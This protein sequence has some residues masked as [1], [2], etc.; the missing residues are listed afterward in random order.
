MSIEIKKNIDLS[1]LTTFRIGGKAKF[2]TEIF[3]KDELKQAIEF[4]RKKNLNFFILAGGS[5]ILISDEGFDGLTIKMSNKEIYSEGTEVVCGAGAS[6][7]DLVNFSIENSLTG[8]E[9]AAGIPG[10]VGGAVRGNAGAFGGEISD[11]VSE[12]EVLDAKTGNLEVVKLKNE[13]C[14][15]GYRSSL[16]KRD[17][18][19]IVVSVRFKL[20]QGTARESRILSEEIIKKRALKQPIGFSAGSFFKNP[21]T[22]DKSLIE[23]FEKDIKM[24]MRGD[25][26]PAGWFIEDL[27]LKGKKIGGAQVSDK[28]ANFIINTGK[29][30]AED[31]IILSSF[32]KQKVRDKYGIQLEEEINKIGF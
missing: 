21:S 22:T 20:S 32:L 23:K 19:L 7:A 16:I 24:K 25:K 13:E 15:F 29:A 31:V 12:V 6:L 27:G 10:T 30:K 18:N 17:S 9:W 11:S 5:N 14:N 26:L 8:L 3:N 28:H 2:F 1:T 4:S